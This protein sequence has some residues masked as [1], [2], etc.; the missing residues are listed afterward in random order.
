MTNGSIRL[1]HECKTPSACLTR[2][3]ARSTGSLGHNGLYRRFLEDSKGF[4]STLCGSDLRCS[5]RRCLYHIPHRS[6]AVFHPY[7]YRTWRPLCSFPLEV[8]PRSHGRC[9]EHVISGTR[10]PACGCDRDLIA[11]AFR[12]DSSARYSLLTKQMVMDWG[13]ARDRLHGG[14]YHW[15]CGWSGRRESNSRRSS[16]PVASCGTPAQHEAFTPPE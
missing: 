9:L 10:P 15:N 2:S 11:D 12:A 4:L 16:W 1:D 8:A 14:L 7:F 5:G 3:P 6:S 13:E